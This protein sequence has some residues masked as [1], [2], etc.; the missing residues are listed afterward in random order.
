MK[1]LP[2]FLLAIIPVLM[3]QLPPS[4]PTGFTVTLTNAPAIV[5][6]SLIPLTIQEEYG[7]KFVNSTWPHTNGIWVCEGGT[8][9]SFIVLSELAQLPPTRAMRL[10]Y[11]STNTFPAIY[12]GQRRAEIPTNWPV[13]VVQLRKIATRP[14]R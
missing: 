3:G 11:T 2:F 12:L 7:V 13:S 4:T 5:D 10:A 1:T 8:P 6:D 9:G 14:T